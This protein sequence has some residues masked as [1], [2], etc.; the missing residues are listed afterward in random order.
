MVH[1]LAV[2]YAKWNQKGGDVEATIAGLGKN[3]QKDL[4]Y[5]E[6]ILG[7]SK[8]KFLFGDEPTA[9]DI[10]MHFSAAF[11]LVRELGTGGKSWPK[12]NEWI[13]NCEERQAYKKAVQHTGHKL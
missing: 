4:D 7:Q 6:A 11:I 12:I 5:L 13:K 9:A 2:L 3:V 10:M 1:G 8:G